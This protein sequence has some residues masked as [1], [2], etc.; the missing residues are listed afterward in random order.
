[1]E[2]LGGWSYSESG[3]VINSENLGGKEEVIC[4]LESV[5][6]DS[7]SFSDLMSVFQMSLTA[8]LWVGRAV[9]PAPV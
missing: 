5:F 1:M 9:I 7:L 6:V 3:D 2:F 4:N 8:A